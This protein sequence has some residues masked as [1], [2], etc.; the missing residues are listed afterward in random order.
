MIQSVVRYLLT[1]STA[2][3]AGK[4]VLTEGQD[5]ASLTI[6]QGV[7]LLVTIGGTILWSYVQKLWQ[8]K[9]E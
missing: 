6:E 3:L 1:A 8:K 9:A 7:I 5:L 4:G 2:F